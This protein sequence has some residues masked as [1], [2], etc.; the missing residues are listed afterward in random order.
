MSTPGMLYVTMQPKPGLPIPQFHEWYNNE[1]GPTRLRL[2]QIFPNG[3]RYRAT[4]GKTPEFLA[5]YDVTSMSH[6][7]TSTY[8]SLRE[9]RS[10]READ[11]IG[12]VDVKRYFWDSVF[13][14]ESP[15]FVPLEQ[16][17][18][19]EAEGIVLLALEL[20]LT[21]AAD[22]EPVSRQW[23]EEQHVDMLSKIPGWL[24]SRVLRTSTLEVG[25][26]VSFIALHEFAKANELGD[27]AQQPAAKTPGWE[28]EIAGKYATLASQRQYSLFY[29]F[30]PAPRDLHNLSLLPSPQSTFVSADALTSTSNADAAGP[31]ITSYVTAPSDGLPIPYRLEGNPDPAAPTIA[32]CNSLL[33]SL[34]MWDAFVAILRAQRPQYRILRYDSRGR[35]ALPAPVP[36]TLDILADD[37]AALLAALRIPRLHALV[38][39]SQGGATALRFALK[40]PALLQTLVACDF[41]AASSPANTGAWKERIAMA[42]S[43]FAD[44]E[45]AKTPVPGIRR[46]AEITVSR[47]FHPL[48]T[49]R[50]PQTVKWMEDMVAAN[51]VQGFRFG[52]QALWD[53]DMRPLMPACGVPALLVAGEG[54]GGGALVKAM[55]GFAGQLGEKGAEVV[56]VKEAGHL[57]MVENPAG[58]WEAVEGVL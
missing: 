41:N 27:V 40:H 48:T 58:F 15:L 12:Q 3:L 32:F 38:G 22:A 20:K 55:K 2:P 1:H 33:T 57:P 52:C 16:L 23:L 46:L 14:K 9:N 5:A 39:V 53:Y 8:T 19:D 34:H 28:E 50:Q 29:V 43:H 45:Q 30:G 24:R 6:L 25:A 44:D 21:D 18:D 49:A 35:H 54:D 31:V 42:E 47:W 17:T 26:P 4:D 10:S 13:A 7:Q 51:D 37:L 56:E 36:A 11:T